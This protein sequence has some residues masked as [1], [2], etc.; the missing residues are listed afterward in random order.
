[1]KYKQVSRVNNE[2]NFKYLSLW[3]SMSGLLLPCLLLSF[4]DFGWLSFKN[5]MVFRNKRSFGGEGI[6]SNFSTVF[7]KL[8]ES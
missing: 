5:Y 1:M 4:I 7:S 2:K 3:Y 8:G 6:G